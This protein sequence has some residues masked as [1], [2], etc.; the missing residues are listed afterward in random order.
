VLAL[1]L[2]GDL[3]WWLRE[4]FAPGAMRVTFL[5]VGQG[6]SAVIELPTGDVVLVDGGGFPG[7]R[8]DV[9]AA[10]LAPFLASRKVRRVELLVVSHTHPDHYAGLET[11]VERYRPRELWWPGVGGEGAQW[12]RFVARARKN[13]VRVRVV[14]RGL[15]RTFG[16]AS[17]RVLHPSPGRLGSVNDASLVLS[18]E[19][20][21]RR[22]VFT[23]DIEAAGESLLLREAS[24]RRVDLVKV[25]H[26]GSRT[27]STP[28]VVRRLDP[29]YAVISAGADNRYGHPEPAVERR[30]AAAGTCV[31]RTDRCGAVVARL[32]EARVSVSPSVP[33]CRCVGRGSG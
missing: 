20:R 32:E 8:F 2:V 16:D 18:A 11:I 9:G 13:G 21:E 26:H 28:E 24:L 6:D 3:A 17:L 33:D 12:R 7:S 29:A 1:A 15:T 14:A 5:D 23:G 25:A 31:L 4:R 27:S 19:W 10:V 30:W 22:V